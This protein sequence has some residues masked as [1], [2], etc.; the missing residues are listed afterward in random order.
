MPWVCVY[1]VSRSLPPI[2]V[3]DLEHDSSESCLYSFRY[4]LHSGSRVAFATWV[5]TA[6]QRLQHLFGS[7]GHEYVEE[8]VDEGTEVEQEVRHQLQ[9]CHYLIEDQS[10]EQDADD[11]W[12]VEEGVVGPDGWDAPHR[13]PP[14]WGGGVRPGAEQ[15]PP[16]VHSEEKEEGE[17]DEQRY[18][19]NELVPQHSQGQD[20]EWSRPRHQSNYSRLPDAPTAA[21]AL[22]IGHQEVTLLSYEQHERDIGDDSEV[23]D[24]VC[25]VRGDDC[26]ISRVLFDTGSTKETDDVGDQEEG[27]VYGNFVLTWA[28]NRQTRNIVL[29]NH[30][31]YQK[32]GVRGFCKE[33]EGRDSSPL[34][35]SHSH[36]IHYQTQPQPLEET[37]KNIHRPKEDIET[38][39]TGPSI[40][41]LVLFG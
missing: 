7:F 29:I 11:E 1:E 14:L 37:I 30:F 40:Y 27:D 23:E 15:S 5:S 2:P 10:L 41:I 18:G 28:E 38:A 16:R 32:L 6:G 26:P 35:G 4:S 25:G 31:I 22:R 21:L 24:E 19:E 33:G 9:V 3:W 34:Q 13:P 39:Q 20:G 8:G 17:G 12:G 36:T